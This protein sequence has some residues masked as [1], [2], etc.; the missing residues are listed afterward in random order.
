MLFGGVHYPSGWLMLGTFVLALFYGWIYLR[1]RNV[2]VLGIFHGWLGGLFYYTVLDR[3]P[4]L[5]TFGKLVVS[6]GIS[7]QA[8]IALWP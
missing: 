2:Y 5:E 3:D 8:Y 7:S 4:F 1:E 6:Q